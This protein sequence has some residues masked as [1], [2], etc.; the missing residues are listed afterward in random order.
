[1]TKSQVV[2]SSE[3]VLG[4]SN[5]C[6]SG[7]STPT[8]AAKCKEAARSLSLRHGTYNGAEKDGAWF[9]STTYP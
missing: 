6:P 3:V 4:S 2:P 8:S 9:M 7:Y 1:M 5:A